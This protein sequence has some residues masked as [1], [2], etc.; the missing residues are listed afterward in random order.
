MPTDLI[1]MTYDEWLARGR[2]LFG[3][4]SLQWRM[5]CP[6]CGHVQTPDDFRPFKD[7][8]AT[9]DSARQECIGRY[10]AGRSWAYDGGDGPCDYAAYGLFHIAPVIVTTPDGK[11]HFCFAF[12]D[13][14]YKA[15]VAPKPPRKRKWRVVVECPWLDHPYESFEEAETRDRARYLKALH[16]HDV[17]PDDPIGKLLPMIKVYSTHD[18]DRMMARIERAKAKRTETTIETQEHA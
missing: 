12:D 2:E 4:N 10:T 1:R 5:V 14:I 15:H 11:E 3:E 8:G 18:S 17:W 7:Q 9:P 16:L 13:G 6:G